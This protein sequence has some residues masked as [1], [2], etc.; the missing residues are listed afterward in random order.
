ML[1]WTAER[2]ELSSPKLLA[3]LSIYRKARPLRRPS[4]VTE[5]WEAILSSQD[6]NIALRRRD[7]LCFSDG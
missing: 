6:D 1:G 2:K 3:E 7:D 4:Q 5:K